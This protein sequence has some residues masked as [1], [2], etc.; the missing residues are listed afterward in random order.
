MEEFGEGNDDTCAG[1]KKKFR[2]L[3]LAPISSIKI[4]LLLSP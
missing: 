4:C 1:G 3:L 2:W